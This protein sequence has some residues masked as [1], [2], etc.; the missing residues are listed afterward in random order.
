MRKKNVFFTKK[1]DQT[2]HSILQMLVA[3][4]RIKFL[5]IARKLKLA[6]GTIHARLAKYKKS[7]LVEG[8]E[9]K[10]NLKELGY[11]IQ[12][13]VGITLTKPT[14]YPSV[15][16]KLK[17]IPEVL[18]IHYTTG[19]FSLFLKIVA[20]NID[21]FHELLH[22]TIQQIEGVESTKTTISLEIPLKRNLPHPL[23]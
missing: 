15:V 12:S 10:L 6:G 16:K 14:E 2:D 4:G 21:H 17:E 11:D 13:F 1:F 5:D 23:F 3:D 20:V 8:F 18:E 9:V 22:Y 19:D 7:G